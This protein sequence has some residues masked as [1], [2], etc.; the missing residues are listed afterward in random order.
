M[1]PVDDI[2]F[3]CLDNFLCYIYFELWKESME[4]SQGKF[5]RNTKSNMFLSWQTYEGLQ[6]T[7][8]SFS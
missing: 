4:E 3:E 2:R 7:V 6:V 5:T 8:H 1:N